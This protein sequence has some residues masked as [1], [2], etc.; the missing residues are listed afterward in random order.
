MNRMRLTTEFGRVTIEYNDSI[1]DTRRTRTFLCS[2][3]YVYEYA[4]GESTQVCD[5]LSRLG[6]TLKCGN[7]DE[8][9]ALIRRQYK[10]MQAAHKRW[11]AAR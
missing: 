8:L 10:S 2:G 6:S 11:I 9:P 1:D 5:R 3:G 7:K 4:N